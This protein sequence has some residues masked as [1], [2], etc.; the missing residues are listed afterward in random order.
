VPY[1]REGVTGQIKEINDFASVLDIA[2]PEHDS[3][4]IDL[5]VNTVGRELRDLTEMFPDRRDPT[6]TEGL[7]ERLAARA[8]LKDVVIQFRHIG[9]AAAAGHFD[10]AEAVYQ[11][12]RKLSAFALPTVLANAEQWSLFNLA[13]YKAHYSAMWQRLRQTQKPMQVSAAPANAAAASATK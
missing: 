4:V 13:I 6:V 8:A 12:Y 5:A 3:A 7:K 11:D 2:I 10:E 9:I 1:D